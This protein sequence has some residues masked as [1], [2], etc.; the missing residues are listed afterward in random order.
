MVYRGVFR[1]YSGVLR[2]Y[3]SVFRVFS[4]V[5]RVYRGEFR[6]YRGAFRR[7]P[8][9]SPHPPYTF[10]IKKGKYEMRKKEK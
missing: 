2:V 10:K 6:V 9:F 5:F 3:S 8:E 1:V 4:G 7:R